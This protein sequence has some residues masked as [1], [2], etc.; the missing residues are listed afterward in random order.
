M[1]KYTTI[2]FETT[3][4]SLGNKRAV[5]VVHKSGEFI[6]TYQDTGEISCINNKYHR[7]AF[8]GEVYKTT[9]TEYKRLCA[10]H[11]HMTN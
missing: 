11:K 4:D 3:D 2:K 10:M 5:Y 7:N 9:P 1:S 6:N 8:K